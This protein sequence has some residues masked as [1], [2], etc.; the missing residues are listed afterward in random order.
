MDPEQNTNPDLVDLAALTD[1]QL[2]EL[3]DSRKK[4]RL[5]SIIAGLNGSTVAEARE[6]ILACKHDFK[7]TATRA[8]KP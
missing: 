6:A 3:L 2:R 8:K 5:D 7:I 1:E 4:A